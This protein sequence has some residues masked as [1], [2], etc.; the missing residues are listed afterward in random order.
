MPGGA[1]V[2]PVYSS[3]ERTSTS[4]KPCFQTLADIVAVG[5]QIDG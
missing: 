5:A 1:V 4:P 3:F 2:F